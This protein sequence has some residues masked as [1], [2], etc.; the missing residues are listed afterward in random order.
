MK[1]KLKISAALLLSLLV[2]KIYAAEQVFRE[3]IVVIPS[4]TFVMGRPDDELGRKNRVDDEGPQR[5]VIISR[6]FAMPTAEVTKIQWDI[7]RE[8]AAQHGYIDLPVG[9][10]GRNGD[11]SGTHPVTE[12]SWYDALKWCNARSEMEGR[13]PC[14]TFFGG[15]VYRTGN[16]DN[17]ICDW[18]A[19]GYRLPTEAEWEYACRAGTTTA[20]YTGPITQI[21]SSPLDPNLDR[22]GWYDGNSGMNTHPVRQ[23]QPNAWG[24]Y[25]MHGNV[26]EWCWDQYADH[27]PYSVSPVSDPRGPDPFWAIIRVFR[28]GGWD[29]DAASCRSAYRNS[30]SPGQYRDYIGFRIVSND[31]KRAKGVIEWRRMVE[32]QQPERTVYAACPAK[33]ADATGLVVLIHG[34]QPAWE[35]V[36]VRWVDDMAKAIED[37]FV[38]H[39]ITTWQVWPYKWVEKARPSAVYLIK[40]AT[41][42]L[43][44]GREE[45]ENLGNYILSQGWKDVQFISHSAGAGVAQAAT[46]AIRRVSSRFAGMTIHL[47]FLDPFV[48]FDEVG[49]TTYGRDADWADYYF[50][51]D[52]WT[53]LEFFRFTEGPI[54]NA[55]NVNVTWVDPNKER[56]Q[57]SYFTA[58][59]IVSS[60]CVKT[61]S[62][63]DWPIKF[64]MR[65]ITGPPWPDAKGLGF[66]LSKIGGGLGTALGVGKDK[67]KELGT[68]DAPC[69][70]FN[71]G[72]PILASP[73]L[74][75]A[76]D[77]SLVQSPTG[78]KE[79]FGTGLALTTDSP[80]WVAVSLPITNTVNLL[81]LEAVFTSAKGAE[82]LFTVYWGTNKI[83]S[84]DERV[85]PAGLQKYTFPLPEVATSGTT[86]M[87]GFR[88]DPFSNVRSSITVTNVALGFRGLQ[89]PFSLS[90]TGQLK[91]G[92][93]ILQLNGPK[94]FT[95]AV[96]SSTDLINWTTA[97]LLA[98]T[99]G[100][101]HFTVPNINNA[102]ARFYR[103][104]GP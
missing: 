14:Y 51:H 9:H 52:F 22:A 16:F 63:H 13:T 55:Y 3:D 82:G 40:G 65:T 84:L 30:V 49:R 50:T 85:T 25:D 34:W 59:G 38:A 35:P 75:F 62:S 104:V 20:F 29:W 81:T 8:W 23:K 26:W 73:A 37:Y 45:G 102:P 90:F 98:N 42:A 41:I 100:T 96:E 47:T 7:V 24:L 54:D 99:D 103:A 61:V 12:I 33:R 88:L 69:T 101:V 2:A 92:I 18:D 79:I 32:T 5:M 11:A 56:T 28:G 58:K 36:D 43:N 1:E 53:S 94:G 57:V 66:P 80:A 78:T 87:L 95:Y 39:N 4:G 68:P 44:N 60:T 86:R 91:G 19:D 17:A 21:G 72:T 83:G 46:D 97:A 64:Y 31:T 70:L 10:N 89:E 77:L 48:G 67:L 93:P 76:R 15:N 71:P 74:D 6:E 27:Y